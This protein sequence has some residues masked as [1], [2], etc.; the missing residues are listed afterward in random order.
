MKVMAR[1]NAVTA[2]ADYIVVKRCHEERLGYAVVYVNEVELE[3]DRVAVKSLEDAPDMAET[4]KSEAWKDA[5]D[6][7]ETYLRKYPVFRSSFEYAR[8]M[9]HANLKW[10][11]EHYQLVTHHSTEKDF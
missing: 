9:C 5:I 11:L 10:L 2:Y 7:A 8:G 6:Q 1:K 3:R 4:E